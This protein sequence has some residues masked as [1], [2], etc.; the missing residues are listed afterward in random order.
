MM[1]RLSSDDAALLAMIAQ[2][3]GVPLRVK[4]QL[5]G[6]LSRS[7]KPIGNVLIGVA[8]GSTSDDVKRAAER[9]RN[10]ARSNRESRPL[11]RYKRVSNRA[12]SRSS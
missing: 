7:A 8:S 5:V 2:Y 3:E 6:D 9:L 10:W 4:K 1:I 11:A 12:L